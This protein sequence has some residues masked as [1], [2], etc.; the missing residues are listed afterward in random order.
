V[1]AELDAAIAE[2]VDAGQLAEQLLGYF[3]DIMAAAVGCPADLMLHSDPG[4]AA[5]LRQAGEQL[6]LET[7]LAILQILDQAV[8]RMRQSTQVR[9]LLEMVL[10]RICR[11]ES[12]TA[13]DAL[14]AQLQAGGGVAS[15]SA[16]AGVSSPPAGRAQKKTADAPPTVGDETLNGES[17]STLT[18]ENARILWQQALADLGD[19]TED[20]GRLAESVAISAPNRL[21]VSFAAQYTLQKETCERRKTRIEQALSARVDR[22][23]GIEFVVRA[24]ETAPH[25]DPPPVSRRQL[26]REKEN[27]PFVRQAMDL[28]DAEIIRLESSRDA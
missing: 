10:V 21:V 25:R 15:P 8:V 1:L 19:M 23:V 16:P 22:P 5:G 24:G 26:Q 27:D 20:A 11:L 12:L 3:R 7:V 18:G 28:F 6:G 4:D 13:I 2:G 9:T 17:K 14:I